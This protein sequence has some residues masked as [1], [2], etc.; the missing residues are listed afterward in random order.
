MDII[1]WSW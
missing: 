1:T